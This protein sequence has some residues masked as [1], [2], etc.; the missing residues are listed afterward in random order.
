M[1]G[2]SSKEEK[3]EPSHQKSK[4]DPCSGAGSAIVVSRRKEVQGKAHAEKTAPGDRGQV[5]HAL[6]I[7]WKLGIQRGDRAEVGGRLTGG[8][9]YSPWL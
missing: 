5:Q 8:N 1:E 3:I 2:K 9:T 7:V 4:S 6:F